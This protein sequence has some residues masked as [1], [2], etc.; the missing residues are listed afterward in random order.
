MATMVAI[1]FKETLAL[2]P[3]MGAKEMTSFLEVKEADYFD[4]G[5]GRDSIDDFN[6]IEGDF[7]V[8]NCEILE[9][10]EKPVATP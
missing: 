1:T 9:N 2:I 7:A 5:E 10:D 4:C 3:Y 8:A 6:P